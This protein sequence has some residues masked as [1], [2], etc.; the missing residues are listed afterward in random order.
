MRR[1]RVVAPIIFF[2]LSQSVLNALYQDERYVVMIDNTA[3]INY[4]S[5]IFA[6]NTEKADVIYSLHPEL[7]WERKKSMFGV[8]ASG[9]I[10]SKRF[11]KNQRQDSDDLKSKIMFTYPDPDNPK[12]FASTLSLGFNENSTSD[13]NLGDRTSNQDTDIKFT[14]S[15]DIND[16]NILKSDFSYKRSDSRTG[17]N[18][19]DIYNV[20]TG[21]S[22]KYSDKLKGNYDFRF[23]LEDSLGASRN[24]DIR[25]YLVKTGLEGEVLAKVTGLVEA[26][27]QYRE[28]KGPKLENQIK[29][30]FLVGTNYALRDDFQLM[31]VALK[32]FSSSAGNQSLDPLFINLDATYIKSDKFT[33]TAGVGGSHIKYTQF[34]TNTRIDKGFSFRGGLVY[35]LDETTSLKLN[36]SHDIKKSTAVTS[37]FDQSKASLEF[38]LS[39]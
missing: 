17:S 34:A 2:A 26:G 18:D 12:G 20:L 21:F 4:D 24:L 1:I 27:V 29:P 35:T 5:S 31:L 8:T 6:N 33:F 28:F 10:E 30:Y 16:K 3:A 7:R 9:G 37:T 13:V 36:L 11:H 15:K 23:R 25:D 19:R 39:F 14:L 32:D 22:H 38:D